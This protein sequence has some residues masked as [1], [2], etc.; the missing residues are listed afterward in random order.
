MMA[1]C[2]VFADADDGIKGLSF[3][4][5]N[6]HLLND[7]R[8]LPFGQ[9]RPELLPRRVPDFAVELFRRTKARNLRWRLHRPNR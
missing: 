8:H 9:T 2:G 7:P 1:L 6:H 4:L 3:A 5:L